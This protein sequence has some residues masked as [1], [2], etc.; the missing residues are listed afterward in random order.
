MLNFAQDFI[1]GSVSGVANCLSGYLLDTLKV[2]MQMDPSLK[3]IATLK[4]IIK[5]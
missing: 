2:R 1:C 5:N 4:N 3:M